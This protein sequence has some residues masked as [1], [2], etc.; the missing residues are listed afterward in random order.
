[1]RSR[2]ST[3]GLPFALALGGCGGDQAPTTVASPHGGV[4]ARL[5]GGQVQVEVVRAAAADRPGWARLYAYYL[6]ADLKPLAQPPASAIWIPKTP[7]ARPVALK[8]TGDADPSKAGELAS[9]DFEA[10]GDLDGELAAT[11]GGKPVAASIPVR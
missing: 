8:A 10:A 9:A 5:P 1:M 3:L 4:L 11:V 6:D 7:G 2:F